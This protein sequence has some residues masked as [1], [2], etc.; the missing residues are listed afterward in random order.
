MTNRP[1]QQNLSLSRFY[2]PSQ[3]IGWA[4]LL[5]IY[6]IFVLPE[7]QLSKV[8]IESTGRLLVVGIYIVLLAFGGTHILRLWIKSQKWFDLSVSEFWKRAISA[9]YL[10]A[11]AASILEMP[12]LGVLNFYWPPPD[13][14]GV[15]RDNLGAIASTLPFRIFKSSLFFGV[16]YL[17]W[18][19]IYWGLIAWNTN[20]SVKIHNEKLLLQKKSIEFESLTRQLNPHFLFNSLNNI[21]ALIYVDRDRASDMISSLSSI[22]RYTLENLKEMIELREEVELIDSFLSLEKIRLEERLR[23]E[24]NWEDESLGLY[25]PAMFLQT[26]IENAIKHGINNRIEGGLLSMGSKCVSD[27]VLINISNDG[28]LSSR[29]KGLGLGLENSR[30]RLKLL[31]NGKASLKI[32]QKDNLVHTELFIPHLSK[33]EALELSN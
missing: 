32:Y 7:N 14:L 29:V 5:S 15:A 28:E 3:V 10:I 9:T 30:Q 20:K 25:V 12:I 6:I 1:T 19:G 4:S 11:L 27:G 23:I 26:L 8:N 2:W 18:T 13:L 31:F 16:V 33:D 21:R 24:R 22:L 17:A